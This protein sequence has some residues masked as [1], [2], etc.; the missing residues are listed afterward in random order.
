MTATTQTVTSFQALM[1]LPR[2]QRPF[3]AAEYSFP[4]VCCAFQSNTCTNSPCSRAHVC[5]GC[6][7]ANVGYNACKC[8]S[9]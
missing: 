8:L 7:K 3:T 6:G 4:G 2:S 9:V 1:D 5:I